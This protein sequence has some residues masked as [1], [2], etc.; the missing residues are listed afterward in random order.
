MYT[1]SQEARSLTQ[2]FY[3]WDLILRKHNRQHEKLETKEMSQRV[4]LSIKCNTL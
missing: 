1:E 4:E 2:K 3:F